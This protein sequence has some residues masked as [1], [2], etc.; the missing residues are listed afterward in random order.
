M[1]TY[2]ATACR[3]RICRLDLGRFDQGRRRF[4]MTAF[5]MRASGLQPAF[6]TGIH[7]ALASI[8]DIV[9]R[10]GRSQGSG[11]TLVAGGLVCPIG[12]DA[13][14]IPVRSG[15][16]AAWPDH[17]S[18]SCDAGSAERHFP[19]PPRP[20]ARTARLPSRPAAC[21]TVGNNRSAW[22]L[23]A[24]VARQEIH[25]NAFD[26]FASR[27]YNRVPRGTG[28]TGNPHGHPAAMTLAGVAVKL[29]Y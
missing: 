20:A 7:S 11:G 28:A 9:R 12:Q 27:H 19:V 29:V 14:L 2:D 17:L 3:T 25:G 8:A 16:S 5:L 6:P 21:P 18:R 26:R 22:P 10:F 13:G 23:M 1:R 4:A 24:E 15:R